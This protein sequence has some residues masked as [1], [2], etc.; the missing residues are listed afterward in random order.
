MKIRVGIAQNRVSVRVQNLG[1]TALTSACASSRAGF[2]ANSFAANKFRTVFKACA[3]ASQNRLKTGAGANRNTAS[4]MLSL[5][6]P[7]GFPCGH[8]VLLNVRN[9]RGHVVLAETGFYAQRVAVIAI[10]PDGK[11]YKTV[12][13]LHRDAHTAC[14]DSFGFGVLVVVAGNIVCARGLAVRAVSSSPDA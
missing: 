7:H 3:P 12:F 2:A 1:R 6:W 5:K 10:R 14:V 11:L 9:E 4:I 8:F 13:A